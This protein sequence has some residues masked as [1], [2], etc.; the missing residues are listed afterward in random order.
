MSIA[1]SPIRT[2]SVRSPRYLVR[3]GAGRGQLTEDHGRTKH[4]VLSTKYRVLHQNEK[5]C[6]GGDITRVSS[7]DRN[8]VMHRHAADAPVRPGIP[9][10][11]DERLVARRDGAI[12][13]H[14]AVAF[15]SSLYEHEGRSGGADKVLRRRG[16]A[17]DS[18][19]AD[20]KP[21]RL[22]G[23]QFDRSGYDG[24]YEEER[25]KRGQPT[26]ADSAPAG[27]REQV[28]RSPRACAGHDRLA[29]HSEAGALH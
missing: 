11:Q 28:R 18:H 20:M 19:V 22:L 7:G 8:E 14:R 23:S 6:K 5:R 13:I 29:G 1:V 15:F 10:S 26:C 17:N 16:D 2:W 25:K 3:F 27:E 21:R 4:Q 12:P 9:W 24:R